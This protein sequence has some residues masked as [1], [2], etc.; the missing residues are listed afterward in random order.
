MKAVAETGVIQPQA[1]DRRGLPA[2][3]GGLEAV[4]KESGLQVGWKA[5]GGM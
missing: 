3:P 1:K 5:P 2:A 4:G